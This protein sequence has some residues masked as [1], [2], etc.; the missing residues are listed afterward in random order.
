MLFPTVHFQIV[1][2]AMPLMSHFKHYQVKI[3][4]YA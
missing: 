1:L 4:L 2:N 3:I